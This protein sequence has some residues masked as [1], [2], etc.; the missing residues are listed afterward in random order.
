VYGQ[1]VTLE[2]TVLNTQ[3]AATPSGTVTFF[4]GTTKVGTAP[5][6]AGGVA[7]LPVSTLGAGKHALTASFSDP[8]GNFVSSG[9]LA[10]VPLVITKASTTTA[11]A[12]T[13][14]TA[15]FGQAV[16]FTATVAAVS[17]STATP[18]GSVTF[19]DGT[20]VLRTVVLSGGS[21]SFT[22][23]LLAVNS[24]TI[25]A[26]YNGNG[27]FKG[28]GPA[29]SAVTVS[30]DATTAVVTSSVSSPVY[31]QAVTLR[32]TVTAATPGSG[33]PTGT[34]TFYDGTTKLGTAPLSNGVASIKTTALAVS[35]NSITVVYGGD[36]NFLGTTSAALSLTVRQD[37]TRA[38]VTSSSATAQHGTAVTLTAT[39]L[40]GVPGSGT[41]TGTVSFWDGST[42]LN[43]VNLSGGVAQLTYSFSGI[44]IHKIKAVYNGDA[45]FL[46][47]TSAVLTETI[48]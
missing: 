18:T 10:A 33:K 36:V 12:A 46:S 40:A 34:V 5:V 16:T 43:T 28:S 44:G 35:S 2:A 26:T 9:S 6:G 37:A 4:D 22:T 17:P 23:S 19:K 41:P 8:A 31:G 27:N 1:P 21:A 7:T 39:V 42:L 48:T 38:V 25:T 14:T 11:L 20:T 32:A 29:T 15:V 3:T 24:H 13:T 47:T 30:Q 45:D